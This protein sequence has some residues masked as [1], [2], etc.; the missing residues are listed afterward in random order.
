M[1]KKG[2]YGC[3][4]YNPECERGACNLNPYGKGYKPRKKLILSSYEIEKMFRDANVSITDFQ[5]IFLGLHLKRQL[6]VAFLFLKNY[7]V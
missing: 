7:H 1:D 2:C 4:S 5:V 3:R 6:F